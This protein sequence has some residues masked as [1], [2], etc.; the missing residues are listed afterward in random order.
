[1]TLGGAAAAAAAR[2]AN[3]VV[4]QELARAELLAFPLL[5]LL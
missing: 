1:V 4:Q 3:Q 5:L 2:E